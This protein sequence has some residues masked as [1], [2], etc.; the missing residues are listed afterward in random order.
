MSI[1]VER[2]PGE[3]WTPGMSLV[4]QIDTHRE[5]IGLDSLLRNGEEWVPLSVEDN[6][7]FPVIPDRL[8]TVSPIE[9]QA[10]EGLRGPRVELRLPLSTG[11]TQGH[12]FFVRD[13]YLWTVA[14]AIESR[15][16]GQPTWTNDTLTG[17][18]RCLDRDEAWQFLHWLERAEP[19]NPDVAASVTLDV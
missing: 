1:T 7:P 11:M 19:I 2:S 14:G 13:R 16:L 4:W 8:W 15:V 9:R 18:E 12:I 5:R 17:V 10:K 6:G 3:Q